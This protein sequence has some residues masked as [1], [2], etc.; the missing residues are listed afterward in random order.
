MTTT[1]DYAGLL[2]SFDDGGDW[3]VAAHVRLLRANGGASSGYTADL[4]QNL[5]CA[6]RALLES[7]AAL[8]RELQYEEG[9]L[10]SCWDDLRAAEAERDR[11]A[12]RVAELEKAAKQAEYCLT[13]D[14]LADAERIDDALS[15]IRRT[16]RSLVKGGGD[17]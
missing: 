5:H 10:A 7:N 6:L 13:K 4:L 12:E 3:D 15:V 17:E 1:P 8:E 11:L 2:T 9:N 16:A 14:S